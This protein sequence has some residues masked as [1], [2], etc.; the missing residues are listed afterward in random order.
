MSGWGDYVRSGKAS[1]SD[2]STV[3]AAY[4]AY[5]QSMRAASTAVAVYRLDNNKSAFKLALDI[6][7]ASKNLLIDAITK[8][9][10]K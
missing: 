7:D 5:Q 4:S 3:H 1:D 8:G 10:M 2:Q 9:K 6:L